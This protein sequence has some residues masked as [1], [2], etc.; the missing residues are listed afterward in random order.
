M[1]NHTND[2]VTQA[3]VAYKELLREFLRVT[4]LLDE[5]E[6]LLKKRDLAD[7]IKKAAFEGAKNAI[8]ISL[9]EMQDAIKRKDLPTAWEKYSEIR[10]TLMPRLANDLLAMLGGLYVR[11]QCLDNARQGQDPATGRAGALS[12]S[13]LAEELAIKDLNRR[14]GAGWNSVLIVG[15]ERLAHSEAEIIRL[16]YPACDIWHLP[17][18]AH[19][20]GY[21]VARKEKTGP[22]ELWKL[23]REI[24]EQVDPRKHKGKRPAAAAC[25]LPEVRELWERYPD[26]AAGDGEEF[27][28]A[29]ERRLAVLVDLQDAHFCRLYA[30]AFAT[31]FVGPA[32]VHALLFL[33]FMPPDR[34]SAAFPPF[35]QRFVFALGTLEWMNTTNLGTPPYTNKQLF[36]GEVERLHELREEI[37]QR[38][39][40]E[41]P[42]ETTQAKF[43]PWLKGVHNS[44]RRAFN[45]A[46][47]TTFENWRQ[48]EELAEVI[49][50]PGVKIKRPRPNTWVV[51]NAA[52]L[53]RWDKQLVPQNFNPEDDNTDQIEKN[54]LRLLDENDH[55]I[56]AEAGDD[57]RKS[58][59]GSGAR[60]EADKERVLAFLVANDHEKELKLMEEHIK[61]DQWEWKGDLGYR[62]YSE[63]GPESEEYKA[64]RRLTGKK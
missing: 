10:T 33:H 40:Q 3:W 42:Y 58:E 50:K 9:G 43:D 45:N 63:A 8:S 23:S 21:L 38:L 1:S 31:F 12:F 22:N 7:T 27:K 30:D 61:K 14:T 32:Y 28:R 4:R 6:K 59:S 16:R 25:F 49:E 19:E 46:A 62:L 15:E 18:T 24:K 64:Y 13:V 41:D 5:P 53:E 47:D 34:N 55:D 36:A 17:S 51:V 39:G 11:E 54:V 29:H 26:L 37:Y 57:R 60:R 2:P 56:F 44:L 35:I 20:Y 48:A 52:W